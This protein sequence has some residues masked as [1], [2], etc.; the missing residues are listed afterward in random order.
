MSLAGKH[1]DFGRSAQSAPFSRHAE[2]TTEHLERTINCAHLQ[3]LRL[4]MCREISYRFTA[5]FVQ[6]GT[7]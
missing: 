7:R 6:F 5:D 1:P 2:N 4:A 3:T